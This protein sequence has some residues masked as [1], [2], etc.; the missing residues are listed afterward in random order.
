MMLLNE[1]GKSY[2][3]NLRPPFLFNSAD[4]RKVT[5]FADYIRQQKL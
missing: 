5:L 3:E 1:I 2:P 4:V